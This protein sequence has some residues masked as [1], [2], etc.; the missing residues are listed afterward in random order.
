M[1]AWT[2]SLRLLKAL[3]VLDRLPTSSSSWP[4][5]FLGGLLFA[6]HSV[7]DLAV[8]RAVFDMMEASP[9][10]CHSYTPQTDGNLARGF[11]R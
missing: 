10:V 2:R 9:L 7:N 3:C 6:M 8:D 1:R 11:E 5:L 4:S